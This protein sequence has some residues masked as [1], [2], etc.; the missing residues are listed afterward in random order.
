M[1]DVLALPLCEAV[2]VLEKDGYTVNISRYELNFQRH[3]DTEMLQNFEEYVVKQQLLLEH[4][5]V[6]LTVVKKYR[7]EV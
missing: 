6:E 3:I 1:K 4:K 5:V 7:R 2:A